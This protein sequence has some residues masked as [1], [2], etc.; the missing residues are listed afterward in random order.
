MLSGQQVSLIISEL[1]RYMIKKDYKTICIDLFEP[2]LPAFFYEMKSDDLLYYS[3]Y[4]Y[5]EMKSCF[6]TRHSTFDLYHK[7]LKGQYFGKEYDETKLYTSG[8]QVKRY[9]G[10]YKGRVTPARKTSAN[11]LIARQKMISKIDDE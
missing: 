10:L 3:F 9:Y 4:R 6:P 7:L 1:N 5:I 11:A 2:C 8:L